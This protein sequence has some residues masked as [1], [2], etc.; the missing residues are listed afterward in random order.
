[1][2]ENHSDFKHIQSIELARI[3]IDK[4]RQESEEFRYFL[5][6]CQ[7]SAREFADYVRGHWLQD[8]V[9]REDSIKT[10]NK[11]LAINLNVMNTFCLAVLNRLDLGK[12]ISVRRTTFTQINV[13]RK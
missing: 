9:F 8:V 7:V 6:S 12:K 13:V 10:L 3:H 1:M 11:H 5:L 4:N 2:R